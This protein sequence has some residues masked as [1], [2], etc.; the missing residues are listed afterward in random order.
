MEK[1]KTISVSGVDGS[2]KSTMS[3]IIYKL[4]CK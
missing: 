1:I 2:G 3:L 4:V